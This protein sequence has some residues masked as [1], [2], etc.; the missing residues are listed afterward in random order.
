MVGHEAVG[1]D[2]DEVAVF[3]FKQEIVI[4]LFCQT[5]LKEPLF[6][7]ALPGDVEGGVIQEDGVTGN[8]GHA[9]CEAKRVPG[10]GMGKARE[11]PGS[12][13]EE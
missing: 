4:D 13:E 2:G 6:I 8:R 12:S 9:G 5:G 3:I 7:V 11:K 10:K 1:V